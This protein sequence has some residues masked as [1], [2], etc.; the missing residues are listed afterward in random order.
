MPKRAAELL[1]QSLVAAGVKHLFTLSGNQILPVYDATIGREI[2]LVHTRHEAAAV[3]MAD[4]W[5]RLTETPGVALVTAGP[6]HCNSLSA[7]Y[8][9][10]MA[11]SPVVLLSGHCPRTE[12]GR[13]A[14]Q[15]IEQ[16]AT[17]LPVTKAAWMVSHPDNLGKDITTAL[18]LT[19]VGRPGP[20]HLSLPADVLEATVSASSESPNTSALERSEHP[21]IEGGNTPHFSTSGRNSLI[22]K[23]LNLLSE[24]KRPLILA[25][26]AMARALRWEEV[27]RLSERTGIPALPM[28]SPRGVNDPWLHRATNSLAVTDVVLLVGKKLDFSLRFAE[29]P[30][31]KDTR[32][33]QIDADEKQLRE[34]QRVVLAIPDDPS[35]VVR[36]MVVAAKEWR[37]PGSSW[38]TEVET[39]RNTVPLEWD[40]LRHSD[41]PPLHPLRVCE[42]LQKFFDQGGI[43]ISDGGEFGQWAQAGLQA[44][45][46]LING[47]AGAIGSAF[48]MA[49][50][51]K[52]AY[53]QRQVF[54]I[55]GDGTFGYHALEFDTAVRYELPVIAIVGNDARWNAEYQLQIQNYGA[56]RTVGCELLL[57]RYDKVVEALGG[58]GEFVQRAHELT[59]ALERAVASELPACL[60]V[61][62]EGVQ[63]PTFPRK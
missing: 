4:G 49:L 63:A 36:D 20:V 13:G 62:I 38:R 19:Q 53:P 48:P 23:A 33:I 56:E 46:R 26:P 16:V 50:A 59:P 58:H 7:L 11:E 40:Q 34:H 52:L 22:T 35:R 6:G 57:S 54:V 37:W 32:F 44:Q 45:I 9:A 31:S 27:E 18:S 17:A 12:I 15:E 1:V 3:H 5:G 60:N 30:F 2:Q 47:P 14:F 42:A 39:A 10:L 24:A 43:F 8:V 25:G 21:R 41:Q 28:E 51:A 55:L 29:S 61:T